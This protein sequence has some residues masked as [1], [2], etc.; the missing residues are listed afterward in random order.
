M[1]AFAYTPD[2]HCESHP[3]RHLAERFGTPTYIY[4]RAT[5]EGHYDRL[6]AAFAE[7]HPLICFSVK[8]CP[9]IHIGRIL[10]ERG[11]GMD[12]VSGGE[13][14]RALLAGTPPERIVYAGVG[15]TQTE[16][17]AALRARIAYFNIESEPEF[18]TIASIARRLNIRTRGALRINPDVDPRTHAYTSTGKRDSKFGVDIG[19]AVRFFETYGRDDFLKLDALHLHIGSPVYEVAPYIDAIQK[20]LALID[21]LAARH[22]TVSTLDLGGGFGADYETARSPLAADYA[23]AI[24]PLLRDRAAKGLK[25]ILEPGRSIAANAGVL[26]TRVL[27]VKDGW[28][29]GPDGAPVPKKF[30]IC[31][32]GMNT[33]LRP[34]LYSAFHFVWPVA[35]GPN[36]IP[37]RRAQAQ[38]MPGLERCDVVGPICESSDFLAKDRF[39]PPMKQGDLLA[40]FTA[41]AYGMSM[42]STYN[43]HGLPAEVLVEGASTRLIRRRQAIADLVAP[44]QF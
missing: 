28:G 43:S 9:N 16:I 8:S 30:I 19:R 41:G 13:L 15:K 22:F 21:K 20:A 39:L 25:V 31:D 1:D 34:A 17:D 23:A 12:V 29:A 35:P 14:H 4:S 38:S 18:E 26:L 36:F 27:Y 2:L 44:E 3:L 6:A 37:E 33:L 42:A 40:V 7:L 11:S 10:A 5:L 24:V 32:A